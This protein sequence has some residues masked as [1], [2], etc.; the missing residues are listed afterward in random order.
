MSDIWSVIDATWAAPRT[1]TI[2]S[3][4]IREGQGGGQRVSAATPLGAVTDAEVAQAARAMRDLGQTPLFM[5]RGDCPGFDAQ[6]ASLGYAINDPVVV[7]A[8]PI[9]G[10]VA[11]PPSP[12]S[13]FPI[14]PPL[15]IM[16]ELW[17]SGGIGPE[18]LAVMAASADPKTAILGRAED[19]AVGC[20]FVSIYDHTAMIHAV[21]VLDPYRRK[22]AARN[23][24]RG[25]AMWAQ[26]HGATR[27]A[28]LTTRANTASQAL[29]ASLGLVPVEQYHYR[30]LR[31]EAQE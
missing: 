19:R 17:Q 21:E 6:L 13:A 1:H 8:G 25:A 3:F 23:M 4:L 7:M 15:H 26:S 18:R 20:A 14:W 12:V 5:V 11:E 16:R 9:D 22:G 31:E 2:G 29:F 24:V 30:I 27:L 28:T 10:P